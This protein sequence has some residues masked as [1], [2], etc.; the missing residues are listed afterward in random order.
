MLYLDQNGPNELGT[1]KLGDIPEPWHIALVRF[2]DG[3]SK[4]PRDGGILEQ[5]LWE[6]QVMVICRYLS[7][8]IDMSLTEL[9]EQGLRE[10][11]T[12][13]KESAARVIQLGLLWQQET[14][15]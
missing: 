6:L 14:Q 15:K 4:M 2:C 11:F 9:H 3:Y 7:K 13:D 8:A 1:K 12:K 10:Q 5:N